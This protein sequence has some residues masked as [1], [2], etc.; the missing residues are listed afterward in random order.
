V[1]LLGEGLQEASQTLRVDLVQD[2]VDKLLVLESSE[3]SS[4]KQST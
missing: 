3:S 1:R 2:R 4:S